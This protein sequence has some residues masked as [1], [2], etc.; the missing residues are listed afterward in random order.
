MFSVKF[1]YDKKIGQEKANLI[2]DEDISFQSVNRKHEERKLTKCSEKW[3]LRK[4]RVITRSIKSEESRA[5]S[6]RTSHK[7]M[8]DYIPMYSL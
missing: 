3:D 4:Y 6:D 1:P 8:F 7:A 5:W 2:R